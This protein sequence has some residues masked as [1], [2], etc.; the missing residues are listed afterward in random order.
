MSADVW[1]KVA[2]EAFCDIRWPG[3]HRDSWADLS[4]L[5][6]D[7]WNAAAEAVREAAAK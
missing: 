5:L 1:G 2:Y 4:Q 7:A 6:R 3:C